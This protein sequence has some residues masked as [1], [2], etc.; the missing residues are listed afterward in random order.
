M[1]NVKLDIIKRNNTEP[2]CRDADDANE[3]T[4]RDENGTILL[5]IRSIYEKPDIV[6]EGL[7]H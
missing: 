7:V 4:T 2:A 3:E 6:S 1:S 5:T